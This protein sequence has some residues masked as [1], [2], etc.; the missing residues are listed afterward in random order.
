MHTQLV[1]RKTQFFKVWTTL[2]FICA[3]LSQESKLDCPLQCASDEKQRVQTEENTLDNIVAGI[4]LH[5]PIGSCT[6]SVARYQMSAQVPARC[7]ASD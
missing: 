4:V 6:G 3:L 5:G 1:L 2:T 7:F